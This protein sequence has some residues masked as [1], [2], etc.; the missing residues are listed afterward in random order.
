MK[1]SP[2]FQKVLELDRKWQALIFKD[3]LS[4]EDKKRL[5]ELEVER[6]RASFF[7]KLERMG[8]PSERWENYIKNGTIE[9]TTTIKDFRRGPRLFNRSAGKG[10]PI[11]TPDEGAA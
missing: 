9:A 2:Q 10:D 6:K 5:D 4:R 1:V 8:I 7:L 11:Y 3:Y